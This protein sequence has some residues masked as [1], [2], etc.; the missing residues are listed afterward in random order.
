MTNTWGHEEFNE[1][2]RDARERWH[3]QTS[4]GDRVSGSRLL[5]GWGMGGGVPGECGDAPYTMT[6]PGCDVI[7]FRKLAL[8]ILELRVQVCMVLTCR[9]AFKREDP[10]LFIYYYYFREDSLLDGSVQMGQPIP[11]C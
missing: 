6:S 8:S 4:G 9:E 7:A 11:E 5:P 2:N 3:V 10:L 1:R